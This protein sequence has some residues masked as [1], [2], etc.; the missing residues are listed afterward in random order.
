MWAK[1]TF[2]AFTCVK[3]YVKDLKWTVNLPT[4]SWYLKIMVKHFLAYMAWHAATSALT[5]F[6]FYQDT[7]S[8]KG[9]EFLETLKN[10]IYYKK[11]LIIQGIICLKF[12]TK[13]TEEILV[14]GIYNTNIKKIIR[15]Q[16]LL[17]LLELWTIVTKKSLYIVL[18]Q[19]IWRILFP[20]NVFMRGQSFLEKKFI[21]RL[22]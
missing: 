17:I 19:R 1:P 22:F 12:K 8:P 7:D 6:S 9:I 21:D 16:F 2:L 11:I 20:K 4:I 13:N 5:N 15:Y 18:P 10:S 14:C 3:L